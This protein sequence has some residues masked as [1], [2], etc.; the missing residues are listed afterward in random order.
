MKKEYDISIDR[1]KVCYKANQNLWDYLKNDSNLKFPEF[2][3]IR[4]G[5]QDEKEPKSR[6]FS[7]I[8]F[9]GRLLGTLTVNNINLQ[10]G[11]YCWFEFENSVLYSNESTN[12]K[13]SR[14]NCII[15]ITVVA[16]YLNLEFNNITTCEIACDVNWNVINKVRKLIRNHRQYD[17]FLNGNIVKEPNRIIDNYMEIYSRTR[18]RMNKRPTLYFKQKQDDCVSLKIY[19]KSQELKQKGYAKDYIRTWLD[20]N[21]ADIFRVEVTLHKNDFKHFSS[22]SWNDNRWN[23]ITES[24]N[25]LIN[26][27]NY[28]YALWVFSAQRLLFFRDKETKQN[29]Y[30]QDLL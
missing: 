9:D 8:L 28:L 19:D 7:V 26:D 4:L 18:E 2:T 1:L 15:Y 21:S 12:P 30:L 27:D 20:F 22:Q 6:S 14:I 29:V 23:D 24:L 13:E 5:E 3:L 10:N 17:M 11:E 25:A 16:D